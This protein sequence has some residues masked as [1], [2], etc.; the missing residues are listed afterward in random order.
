MSIIKPTIDDILS[1]YRTDGAFH[2][3]VSMIQP[4]GKFQ[5]SRKG[6]EDLFGYFGT[7]LV[8]GTLNKVGIAEKAQQY[9]PVLADIDIKLID[10]GEEWGEHIYSKEQVIEV[11]HIYQSV[12]KEIVADS[13]DEHFTC[14]L[15]EK[16]IY[17]E[18]KGSNTY[19]KNGFHLHFPYL[20]L[21]KTDQEVHVIPRVQKHLD[22]YKT[23][24][25][26]GIEQSSKVVDR[27]C[28]SVPWLMYG[29]R[30]EGGKP[31]VL[32]KVF[33]SDGDEI[34]VENAF[35]NYI[36]Y[37]ENTSPINVSNN[38]YKNMP[39]ILS[40]V[41]HGRK[42]SEIMKGLVSP[43]KEEIMR[44]KQ[45][46]KKKNTNT[47]STVESLDLASK[48][49]PLLSLS[50]AQDRNEWLTIGWI[51]Y[52]IGNGSP[53]A[54]TLWL[55]FSARDDEKYDETN[56]IYEWERMTIRDMTMGTLRF[57]AS[58]DSPEDYKEIKQKQSEK[59]IKKSFTGSHNDIA[60]VM[61]EMYNNEFVCASVSGRTWYQYVNHHW[62][63]IEEGTFLRSRISDDIANKYIEMSQGI[64]SNMHLYEPGS[65][66]LIMAQNEQKMILKII[67]DLKS[68]PYKNNVM[69]ECAEVFYDSRF[70]E[71][72]DT[73]PYLIA[74]KN[75]V[76]DLKLEK[77]REGRPED[78]L[79]RT[80]GVEYNTHYTNNDDE[81]IAVFKYL[82][83]MFPD[84]SILA[85]FL[86][87][88][89]DVF[90]G[91]NRKK[92]ALFWTGNGDNGK[93]MLH[94]LV[95]MMFGQLAIKFNTS[96][97]T[98]KAIECG[99]AN[100]ELARAGNGIR[101]AAVEEP[102]KGEEVNGGT[103]KT[104]TGNDRYLARDLFEKGKN[105]REVLPM[106]MFI[107]ICN[108]LPTMKGAIAE[109]NRIRV[110]P[111]ETTFIKY[112]QPCPESY[113]EQLLKKQFPMDPDFSDKLPEMAGAF[114]WVLL[115]HRKKR[116]PFVEPEKVMH[117]TREYQRKN[118]TFRQYI[119]EN[120]VE[121]EHVGDKS[122]PYISVIDLHAHI[123]S[124]HK[125]SLPGNALPMK[126]EVLEYF[127]DERIWGNHDKAYRWHGF[128]FRNVKDDIESGDAVVIDNKDLADE[129]YEY[130]YSPV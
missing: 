89:A 95:V 22:K 90:V 4:T 42:T 61:F 28:C 52:N 81:V 27:A 115:E 10:D 117:A 68:S 124:W 105:T 5:F 17:R 60:K 47:L 108:K 101:W 103:L 66:D 21:T 45:P 120:I 25:N 82:E 76:Y 97:I 9:L 7:E 1:K 112:G 128:R 75:G 63:E 116:E 118:D 44:R 69:R 36:V 46:D 113:E 125:A 64:Y 74:F 48:L 87:F 18:T 13:K 71:K 83:Q 111:F 24:K 88:M 35:S 38:I 96:L 77:F 23:F 100:P 109:W 50:R 49:L 91:G 53:E 102:N 106:F 93:S 98:G 78:F 37:D 129:E 56:C 114:A 32:T 92:I 39:R 14:V 73:N 33:G 3:H 79:S 123:K 84:K 67:K 29:S 110:L 20:F 104:L 6:Q 85:Y 99:A 43:L 65:T 86:N 51:L 12:L 55:E 127:S 2:T 8:N 40:I 26:I 30:K 126:E 54:M 94:S 11:I 16:D 59:Y 15:L 70:K 34:S 122:V 119:E 58:I 57:Y 130:E 62:E 80:M 31:Y 19:V 107:F 72:L 41:P 121:V